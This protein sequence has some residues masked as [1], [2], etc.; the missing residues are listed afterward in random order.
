M[1]QPSLLQL[2]MAAVFLGGALAALLGLKRSQPRRALTLHFAVS[3]LCTVDQLSRA[4]GVVLHS[5]PRPDQVVVDVSDLTY[6]DES[7][8][9]SLE[10]AC[11]RWARAGV[12]VTIQ[13]CRHDVADAIERRG[14][15]A[16]IRCA[17]SA[18]FDCSGTVH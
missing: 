13:G 18:S 3:K 1:S 8:M 10:C 6:L 12:A 11:A 15:P 4:A 5:G 7:S 16:Q 14:L 17:P 9:A 2:A